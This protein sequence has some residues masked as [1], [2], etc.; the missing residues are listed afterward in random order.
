MLRGDNG[1]EDTGRVDVM[2]LW[3]LDGSVEVKRYS[4]ILFVDFVESLMVFKHL[5][6]RSVIYGGEWWW[7]LTVM[8]VNPSNT[9]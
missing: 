7:L 2:K 4:K 9:K 5:L 6:F 1:G 8:T 3:I